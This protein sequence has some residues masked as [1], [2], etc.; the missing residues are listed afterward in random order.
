M[1]EES[2]IKKIITNEFGEDPLKIDQ[3]PLKRVPDYMRGKGGIL[4]WTGAMISIAFVYQ[5]RKSVV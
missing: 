2:K 1:V 3:L 5:D 4:Y